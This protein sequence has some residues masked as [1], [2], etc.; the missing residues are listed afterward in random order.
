MCVTSFAVE[1]VIHMQATIQQDLWCSGAPF[2]AVWESS[3]FQGQE[4]EFS[5]GGRCSLLSV[6]TLVHSSFACALTNSCRLADGP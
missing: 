3:W 5:S 2:L 6:W 1:Q 4:S